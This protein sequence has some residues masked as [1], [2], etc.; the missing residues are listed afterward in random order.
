M[1]ARAARAARRVR[2]TSVY[3]RAVLAAYCSESALEVLA[4]R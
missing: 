3:R 4:P 2:Q 1:C